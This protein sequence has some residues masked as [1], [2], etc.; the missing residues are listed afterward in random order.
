[1]PIGWS[2]EDPG[3]TSPVAVVRLQLAKARG[4]FNCGGAD[5]RAFSMPEVHTLQTSWNDGWGRMH[6][7]T[8]RET[9]EPSSVTHRWYVGYQL[10]RGSQAAS[11]R[12]V[13][14]RPPIVFPLIF[15]SCLLIKNFH[16]SC[17]LHVGQMLARLRSSAASPITE[18][19]FS[20]KSPT[21]HHHPL[22]SFSMLGSSCMHPALTQQAFWT[23]WLCQKLLRH[24][25]SIAQFLQVMKAAAIGVAQREHPSCHYLVC[26]KSRP[27]MG[28]TRKAHA[29][30]KQS[31]E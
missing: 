11:A 9:L 6:I 12:G 2:Q 23:A 7:L 17:T 26:I 14:F 20:L 3:G 21:Y 5:R 30:S 31:Q 1:M 15:Y 10:M 24:W 22:L 28:T 19:G 4:Y 8:S 27:V 18:A 13:S 29:V 16:P 25:P